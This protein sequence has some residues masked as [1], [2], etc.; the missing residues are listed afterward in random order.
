MT[1]SEGIVTFDP[2]TRF[3]CPVDGGPLHWDEAGITCLACGRDWP[4]RGAVPVFTGPRSEP[5][6]G[7][8][9]AP[10]P[11]A[12][13]SGDWRFLFPAGDE[14]RVLELEG[15]EEGTALSLAPDVG[16]VVVAV[17]SETRAVALH[18][19]AAD[20]GLDNVLPVAAP[21]DILPF[22][23]EAFDAVVIHDRLDRLAGDGDPSHGLSLLRRL[24]SKMVPGGVLWLTASNRFAAD[25]ARGPHGLDGLRR[26]LSRAG[27]ETAEIFSRPHHSRE[28]LPLDDPTVQDWR[29]ERSVSHASR[30][31]RLAAKSAF[32]LGVAPRRAPGFGLLARRPVTSRGAGAGRRESP[33]VS[34]LAATSRQL[35]ARWE[36]LGLAGDVPG[37]LRYWLDSKDASPHGRLVALP[38]REGEARPLALVKVARDGAAAI[39]LRHELRL[40]R[41]LEGEAPLAAGSLF[42]RPVLLVENGAQ[43]A[44]VRTRLAGA[45]PDPDDVPSALAAAL[46]WLRAFWRTTGFLTG[47]ER[48]LWEPLAR[49]LRSAADATD[50]ARDRSRWLDLAEEIEARDGVALAGLGHGSFRPDR[51]RLHR[52]GI[53][54]VG[55]EYG[56][57]R[58]LPWLDAVDFV[59]DLARTGAHDAG[60][61]SGHGLD[62]ILLGDGP[63]ARAARD[64]LA[65]A[66]EEAAAD[67]S[68]LPLALPAAA[69]VSATRAERRAIPGDPEPGEWRDLA[70]RAASPEI[71]SALETIRP[72]STEPAV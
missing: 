2:A 56:A 35:R 69:M 12:A 52:G 24:R 1:G 51:L 47:L 6:A 17:G 46:R 8:A 65:R 71:R 44:T 50:T 38:F 54:A 60:L 53:G 13:G 68:V 20:R 43:C 21:P 40:L 48:A 3:A 58:C 4:R 23:D 66:L 33:A 14:V 62:R 32:R 25:G 11:A 7:D 29:V 59:L 18:E 67:P 16:S 36:S 10:R 70:R 9:A 45:P 19:E 41:D 30:L 5:Y 28:L 64:F 26:L 63:E 42:P 22:P 34:L 57:S 55:W 39:R 72:G 15:D 61:P 27:W 31:F 49:A 37:R